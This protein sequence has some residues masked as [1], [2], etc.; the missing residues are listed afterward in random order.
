MCRTVSEALWRDIIGFIPVYSLVLG[1]GLW[2]AAKP[3]EWMWLRTPLHLGSFAIP[4]WLLIPITTAVADYI[5]DYLHL[6]FL[7][8]HTQAR[9]PRPGLTAFA[10]AMSLLKMAGFVSATLLT[11]GA[12]GEGSWRSALFSDQ[13]G[14]RGFLAFS[15]SLI[16]VVM[17]GLVFGGYLYQRIKER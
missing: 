14:W 2:F 1:F 6:H 9:T 4:L 13:V 7:R 8:L 5:E 10:S 3:L 15:I 16:T 12:I 11:V 17:I